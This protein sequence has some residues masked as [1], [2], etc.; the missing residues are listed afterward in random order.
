MAGQNFVLNEVVEGACE[1][2]A[3]RRFTPT[4]TPERNG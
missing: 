1:K 3:S 2:E 4:E